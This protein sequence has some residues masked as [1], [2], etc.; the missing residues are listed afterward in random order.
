MFW[1][2][3]WRGIIEQQWN[4]TQ[5]HY[6]VLRHR[7]ILNALKVNRI[8]G[9][10]PTTPLWRPIFIHFSLLKTALKPSPTSAAA[11]RPKNLRDRKGWWNP[12]QTK[13]K[14]LALQWRCTR[15]SLKLSFHTEKMI[16]VHD[17]W[18][19][20]RTA[21][22]CYSDVSHCFSYRCLCRCCRRC[23]S[24]LPTCFGHVQS[25]PELSKRTQGIISQINFKAENIF[26]MFVHASSW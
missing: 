26:D 20:C 18:G 22:A 1:C 21:A 17:T 19:L 12:L 15:S 7:N 16:S 9:L 4:L 8:G 3:P 25:Q 6:P 14:I 5:H 24:C 2:S 10:I 23:L 11:D 13:C